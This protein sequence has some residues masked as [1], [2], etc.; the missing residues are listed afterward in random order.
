MVLPT[1]EQ[2]YRGLPGRRA[3]H[4]AIAEELGVGLA[5]AYRDVKAVIDRTKAEANETADEI[6]A[7]ELER[8]D[9]AIVGIMPKVEV[10]NSRACEVMVKLQERRSRYLGLDVPSK[11]EHTGPEGAPIP[12]D[13][14]ATLID[15]LAGLVAGGTPA[16]PTSS[17]PGKSE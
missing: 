11:H 8:I 12:I 9:A 7:I 14:R 13:A 1:T 4:A 5:T 17:D 3:S 15:R 6:R 2:N 10:G 16:G